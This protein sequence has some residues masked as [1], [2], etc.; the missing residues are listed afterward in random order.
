MK[1]CRQSSNPPVG[2]QHLPGSVRQKAAMCSPDA[3]RGRYLAFCSSVPAM[4][5]PCGNNQQRTLQHHPV[6]KDMELTSPTTFRELRLQILWH[7]KRQFN[8]QQT[9]IFQT[10]KYLSLALSAKFHEEFPLAI[11]NLLWFQAS[12]CHPSTTKR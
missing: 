1:Q 10:L 2:Q 5:I 7:S 6:E 8:K 9:I 3:S 12:F 4:R 11:T